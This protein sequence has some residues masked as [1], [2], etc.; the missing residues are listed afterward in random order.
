MGRYC[1]ERVVR[2]V[3][4]YDRDTRLIMPAFSPSITVQQDGKV[5]TD[6]FSRLDEFRLAN[7]P[8]ADAVAL[9]PALL[10]LD[11]EWAYSCCLLDVAVF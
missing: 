7:F 5:G 1:C 11:N 10:W 6:A 4:N 9:A 3:A 2:Q 8:S